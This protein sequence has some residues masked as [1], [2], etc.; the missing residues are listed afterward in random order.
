MYKKKIIHL[1]KMKGS[2]I[3]NGEN[4]SLFLNLSNANAFL[5]NEGTLFPPVETL[6][7]FDGRGTAAVSALVI[8]PC[9]FQA[10]TTM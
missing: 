7:R 9:I 10:A 2:I 3:R 6:L 1:E 8:D 5:A 4:L